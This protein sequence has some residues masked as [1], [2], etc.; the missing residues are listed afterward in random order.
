MAHALETDAVI[1]KIFE[2]V[3]IEDICRLASVCRAWRNVAADSDFWEKID[4]SRRTITPTMLVRLLLRQTQVQELD[5]QG[6]DLTGANLALVAPRLTELRSL[7]L[8]MPRAGVQD[9]HTISSNF[10]ALTSLVLTS[11]SALVTGPVT[12]GPMHV[13]PPPPPAPPLPPALPL[14]AHNPMAMAGAPLEELLAAVAAAGAQGVPMPFPEDIDDDILPDDIDDHPHIMHHLAELNIPQFQ[15]AAG[16]PLPPPPPGAAGG[17]LPSVELAH[18]GLLSLRLECISTGGVL[19]IACPALTSLKVRR[20]VLPALSLQGSEA[21]EVIKVVGGTRSGDRELRGMFGIPRP[22]MNIAPVEFP[23]LRHVSLSSNPAV[24]DDFLERLGT[25]HISITTLELRACQQT[26]GAG[27]AAAMPAWRRLAHLS[28]SDCDM[29]TGSQMERAL[30]RMPALTHL[31]LRGCHSVTSLSAASQS[32]R[33]LALVSPRAL[34]TLEVNAPNLEELSLE[35]YTPRACAAGALRSLTVASGALRALRLAGCP[36]LSNLN[37]ACPALREL[38]ITDCDEL[39]DNAIGSLGAPGALPE[40]HTLRLTD[41]GSLRLVAFTSSFLVSLRLAGCARLARVRL[42]CNVLEELSL[43]ECGALHAVDVASQAM[44]ALSLGSCPSLTSARLDL[45]RAE[46]L[47]LRGCNQLVALALACPALRRAD[48]TLCSSLTDAA[49]KDLAACPVLEDLQVGACGGITAAG[50]AALAGASGLRRLDLAY[51]PLEDPAPLLPAAQGGLT[52]LALTDCYAM[53]P[54]AL[55]AMLRT[56]CA[57]PHALARLDASY[58]GLPPEAVAEVA[59][60]PYAPAS[61]AVNGVRGKAERLWPALHPADAPPSTLRSLSLVK[62]RGMETFYLGIVPAGAATEALPA[63]LSSDPSVAVPSG[64]VAAATP[65]QGL[66]ELRLGVG[67]FARVAVAL[68]ALRCLELNNC[69]SLREAALA[70]PALERLSLA[71]CRQMTLEAVV[72]AISGCP[73]LTHLDLG[74]CLDLGGEAAAATLR[75]A[76]P[77]L[78]RLELATALPRPRES[79]SDPMEL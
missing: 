33:R 74:H 4:V 66:E 19:A 50:V 5:A 47:S 18:T 34:V 67:E 76:C 43:E 73:V 23:S 17:A 53:D 44:T 62:S 11:G 48:A 55:G 28:L 20:G 71:A 21:L 13:G 6:V 72:Q 30:E 42:E 75:A 39:R 15:M 61:V 59:M 56:L 68:P 32:L 36:V 12:L 3:E 78:L 77:S 2:F 10:P 8:H 58:C 52:H 45:P 38:D 46:T 37:L 26:S 49:L 65:L 64:Y 63:P 31:E 41:C 60:A 24:T 16:P 1:K 14:P 57:A 9:M 70:C 54:V 27:L 7:V 29:L 40:L 79:A 35:P 22:G 51:I 25:N 69:L